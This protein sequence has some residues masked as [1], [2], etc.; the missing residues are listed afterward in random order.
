MSIRTI[1]LSDLAHEIRLSDLQISTNGESVIVLASRP[2]YDENRFRKDL[3]LVD[4]ESGRRRTLDVGLKHIS[5]P[6]FS[7]RGDLIA[8]LADDD[9]DHS[10][11]FV[12]SSPGGTPDQLTNAPEG[13]ETFAWR[14]DG[15]AVAFVAADP[16][17]ERSEEER[18]NRSFEVGDYSYLAESR[19]MP[20]HIWI[21]PLDGGSARKLTSGQEGFCTFFGIISWSS[22][23]RSIAFTSQPRPDSGALTETSIRILDVESGQTRNFGPP[24]SV[25][26]TFA[27]VG[28]YIAVCRPRAELGFS[29]AGISVGSLSEGSLRDVTA[30]LDR[31]FLAFGQGRAGM[32]WTPGGQTLLLGAFDGTH[33]A[34]WLAPLDGTPRR[35]DLK[36]VQATEIAA[37]G[38]GQIV[39]IGSTND[40]PCE[41]YCLESLNGRLRRLTKFNDHLADLELGE[42][43][44]FSWDGP[45]GF[46]GT[47]I[48]TYPVHFDKTKRYPLV[49]DIHGGP[50]SASTEGF[51]FLHHL[52]ANQGWI[53]FSPNYRGSNN[54]GA[55][56]QRAVVNDAG[57][58]P[59]RDVMSGVHAL[60][61]QGNVDEYRLAVSGWSY[62]GFLTAWLTAHEHIW[63]A[64]V[65][66]A[67]VSSWVDWYNLAD[68]NVW[69]GIGLGGSPWREGGIEHY[70]NN[71]AITYARHI[72]TPTLLMS[73]T[74]DRR[75]SVAQSYKLYHA[76][77]D[78]GTEVSFVAYPLAGHFPSDPIH[79]RDVYR[80]WIAWIAQH[81]PDG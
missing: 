79:E 68:L 15:E 12:W 74:G 77:K 7:P 44:S 78:N 49:L 24:G 6:R 63:R 38:S 72:R 30:D 27:P 23:S 67:A 80:R 54:M 19:A 32:L 50:M 10:Q 55:A 28:D 3:V 34:L 53:V 2:D 52:L 71:S 48:L 41:V 11:V 40:R 45:D 9:R 73:M 5:R 20:S 47:G 29:P 25:A 66:G 75:V 31:D 1:G 17:P 64:A 18:H 35:L 33:R 61:S 57:D 42:R 14:P 16:P 56:Y 39:V 62:G 22:D 69:C 13:V 81:M 65:A 4:V 76:L 8:A 37:G 36:D 21:A 46:A 58:G 51:N 26:A 70:L 60:Q 43:T 59:A